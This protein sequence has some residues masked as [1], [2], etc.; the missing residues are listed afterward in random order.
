MLRAEKRT[1]CCLRMLPGQE[2]RLCEALSG[3]KL[4]F[5]LCFSSHSCIFTSEHYVHMGVGF[6]LT[7][8]Q[9]RKQIAN[10]E[11]IIL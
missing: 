3:P 8:S 11:E 2:V 9:N 1:P 4:T 7:G 10:A 6:I 5:I